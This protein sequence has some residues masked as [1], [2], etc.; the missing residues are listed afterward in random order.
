MSLVHDLI[1]H[2]LA[3]D[4]TQNEL[5]I[6][7]SLLRQTICYGK[8]SDPLSV[9]RL[10]QL[11]H[12]R[13]DRVLP[14]IQGVLKTGLFET[15]PHKI[16][17][18]EYFI[19][20]TLLAQSDVKYF[21][22]SLPKNRKST[23]KPEAFSE[24]WVHTTKTHTR[25][26]PT[27]T[28]PPIAPEKGSRCLNN[29]DTKPLIY[30]ASF[31]FHDQVAAAKILDG[32]SPTDAQDCLTLLTQVLQHQVLKTPLGY[33]HQLAKAARENRLDRS[34]LTQL[35]ST[36]PRTDAHQRLIVLKQSIQRLDQKCYQSGG[37]MDTIMANKRASF[38]E[39][40]NQLRRVLIG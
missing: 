20:S 38:V 17:E 12:I 37:T 30:P 27:T 2:A 29:A 24:K 25:E 7:L 13:K 26:N 35:P 15:K 32:L 31:N 18:T 39:E 4:L 5:K 3:A 28:L 21:I 9:K 22:P 10:S 8:T 23:P 40:Y 19:T 34:K 6:F 16:Y 1:D 36:S 14:A 33:L 11:S